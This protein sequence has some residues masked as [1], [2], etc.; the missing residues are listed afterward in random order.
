MEISDSSIIVHF[1]NRGSGL[2]TTD[3]HGYVRGFQIAGSD[4]K[5]YW[6]KATIEGETV[7]ISSDK[8]KDPVAVRYAWSSNPGTL[9]LYNKEGLP[10]VPF[11]TDTWDGVTKEKVF[12]EG[13]RF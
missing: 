9:N 11:R 8:V 13:P 4:K 12:E 3:K 1:E 2:Q 5:F 7:V 10:V 6:A